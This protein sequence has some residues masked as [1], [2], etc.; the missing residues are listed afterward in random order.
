MAF[1]SLAC[2]MEVVSNVSSRRASSYA[3]TFAKRSLRSLTTGQNPIPP[4]AKTLIEDAGDS[5]DIKGLQEI[6]AT[7]A[8][9]H[10]PRL[11]HLFL[12]NI[13]KVR[14]CNMPESKSP[15]P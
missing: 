6:R 9:R 3:P 12:T 13:A 1:F 7:S 2:N 5:V 11:R 14:R 10:H 8:K 15:S 4:L